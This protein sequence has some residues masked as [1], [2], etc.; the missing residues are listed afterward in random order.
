MVSSPKD[1]PINSALRQL[2]ATE[3]NLAKLDLVLSRIERLVPPGFV[4]SHDQAFEEHIRT[5]ADLLKGLP[6]IDGWK[7]ESIPMDISARSQ[8]RLD[9][10]EVGEISMMDS[11]EEEIAAPSRELAEYR[12]RL[13]RVRRRLIRSASTDL[14]ASIEDTIKALNKAVGK[15][16]KLDRQVSSRHW[17]SLKGQMEEL[18]TLMGSGMPRLPRLGDLQRH[19]H[20]GYIQDLIDI[21]EQDWPEVRKGL[22]KSL[23]GEDEPLPVE[24][25]DLASLADSQPKGQVIT[26]LKWDSL[27]ADL[28]ERLIFSLISSAQGYE[29][30]EWL[31]HTNAPDRARDLSVWRVINDPLSGVSRS[32]LIIQCKHW[33]TKSVS[34][35]DIA[36]LKEQI[37]AW[38][39]PKIDV[40]VI[41]TSGRFT[42]DAV[43]VIEKNNSGDRSLKIEPWAESHLEKLLAA[44]PALIAEFGLR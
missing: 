41:A 10:E 38:E 16:P 44:R 23:Y 29:N 9:A 21:V 6:K 2:E 5:Y 32:R 37:S 28:F 8:C 13:S 14:I 7:P 17:N 12:H 36:T 3:A 35:S 33:T 15:K 19:L 1:S 24:V 42:A 4:F 34:P 22:S 31:T 40:L 27:S 25:N 18:E 20:F 39:P 26:K 30:P 43:S 11:V